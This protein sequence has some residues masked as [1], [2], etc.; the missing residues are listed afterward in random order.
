LYHNAK[1]HGRKSRAIK[2][3][4]NNEKGRNIGQ[5]RLSTDLPIFK[6]VFFNY[7]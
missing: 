2:T 1:E 7:A 5:I 4:E 6:K 3:L